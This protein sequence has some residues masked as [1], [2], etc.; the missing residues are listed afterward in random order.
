MALERDA[1]YSERLGIKYEAVEN[2]IPL[3]CLNYER[4]WI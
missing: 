1:S 2:V 3:L 4:A